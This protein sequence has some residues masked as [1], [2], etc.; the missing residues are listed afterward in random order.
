MAGLIAL[1]AGFVLDL[2]LGDP[3]WLYH[4]VCVIGNW[5]GFLEKK[6]RKCFP[7]TPAGEKRAGVL[8]VALVLLASGG[9]PLGILWL[10]YRWSFWAGLA[11]ETFWCYQL[12]AGKSLRVE[13]MRVYR[14][15]SQG[16]LEDAQYAVSMIVGRD[17]KSLTEEG[18]VKATVETVA[19]N[20]S[21]GVIAPMFYM[22]LGGLP[23]MFLY[24]GIN[25][26][27]SMVGYKNDRYLY[28]GRCAAKL[29]DAANYLPARLSGWLMVAASFL[30]RGEKSGASD[31]SGFDGKNAK[32]IYLRDRRNHASPN[33]AQTESA[34]AGA[35]GIQLAGNASYFG[36]VYE[37]PTIG[38]PIRPVE[39][40]DIPRANRL[41]YATSWLGL[42]LL[43]L[44][45]GV[46][47]VLL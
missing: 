21:D 32:K 14:A 24:K 27:D 3:R 15:F 37:K 2:W 26:M 16:T 25:T 29:D 11:V 43:A 9:I 44:V 35:L 47:C 18:V 38:D 34:M 31:F 4:P 46:I 7:E 45:R 17:T 5:I 41:L 12:L 1:C 39:R 13:S 19:E 42:G 20:T 33:S 30:C 28:F 10:L 22:A 8:L 36:K 23:L 40:E 6:L